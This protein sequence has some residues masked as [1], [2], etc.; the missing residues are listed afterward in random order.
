LF[1]F[2]R[3]GIPIYTKSSIIAT[4]THHRRHSAD[5]PSQFPTAGVS[6]QPSGAFQQYGNHHQPQVYGGLPRAV[7]PASHSTSEIDSLPYRHQR[8]QQHNDY[9]PHTQPAAR[10]SYDNFMDHHIESIA[11]SS[12]GEA[13]NSTEIP[14]PPQSTPKKSSFRQSAPAAVDAQASP[15]ETTYTAG[16]Y[17]NGAEEYSTEAAAESADYAEPVEAFTHLD[18]EW[19]VYYSED[20][21]YFL[22]MANEHSQWEDPREYGIRYFCAASESPSG[23]VSEPP[24]SPSP[25]AMEKHGHNRSFHFNPHNADVP[26]EESPRVKDIKP[27]KLNWEARDSGVAEEFNNKKFSAKAVDYSSDSSDDEITSAVKVRYH[28]RKV[29][30]TEG[31]SGTLF[32]EDTQQEGSGSGHATASMTPEP[33]LD[34]LDL[35]HI[36][37]SG[38][39]LLSSPDRPTGEAVTSDSG[40]QRGGSSPTHPTSNSD[41]P[42]EPVEQLERGRIRQLASQFDRPG[43]KPVSPAGTHLQHTSSFNNGRS[44]TAKG[45]EADGKATAAQEGNGLSSQAEPALPVAAV[46]ASLSLQDPVKLSVTKTQEITRSDADQYVNAIVAG[47][48]V[49]EVSEQMDKQGCS[50]AFKLQ[51]L[52]WADEALLLGPSEGSGAFHSPTGKQAQQ[53]GAASESAP[54]AV[55]E[56]VATLKEDAV[57]GKYAKM[58]GMGV[59]P[60]NVLMK[61]K[62]ENVE[63]SQ[64][65]RLMRAAGHELEPEAAAAAPAAAGTLPAPITRRPSANMQNLH[66]NTLP[67]EKLKNSIWAQSANSAP[68]IAETDLHEL[69]RLFGA[70]KATGSFATTRNAGALADTA[71][72]ALQL[73][74]IDKK[75]AQNIVIGLNPFKSLGSHVDLLKALCSLNDLNGKITADS[76]DNFRTLLPTDA[77]LKRID[78]IK[79]SKHP[80]E[81]FFQA[82]MMFYPE[83]PLR[84][85]CFSACLNF[86]SNC[87]ALHARSRKLINACNQ[88]CPS[89]PYVCSHLPCGCLLT[90]PVSNLVFFVGPGEQQPGAAAAAH[91]G[92]GQ[93]DERGHAARRGERLHFGLTDE[94]GQHER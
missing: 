30:A 49:Q 4:E 69:E 26:E 54:P 31:W 45:V 76:I 66:W 91:A 36:A 55:Q 33:A 14:V 6:G 17:H 71:K 39:K 89:L 85:T 32:A 9:H 57:L 59:P 46:A 80:A 15:V 93:R 58:L 2:S 79:G 11:T 67:A 37:V 47:K 56:T 88:V 48:S 81:M 41:V 3:A 23:R 19:K 78:K 83:L 24:K 92:G 35:D 74:H 82:V 44:M 51:V 77:E 87:A 8:S 5:S 13:Y 61:L 22:D 60:G 64:R 16:A 73:K 18:R 20:Q 90:R 86:P 42:F 72:E 63:L 28:T 10:H 62:M 34:V 25:K 50:Q 12:S 68:D 1:C 75:R 53:E 70:Q 7:I 40:A 52:T 38:E 94:D 27:I 43:A 29:K 21:L 65:N 84:L